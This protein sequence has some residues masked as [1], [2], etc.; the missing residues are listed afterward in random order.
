[1]DKNKLSQYRS[2][3]KEIPRIKSDI[4]KLEEKL[5]AVP[6]VK[7]KVSKSGDDFPYIEGHLTV[8]AEEPRTA[9]E[10]RKQIR[11]KQILLNKAE[12]DKTEIVKFIS[13]IEN[14]IDRQIFELLY[15]GEKRMSQKKVG[16]T[17]GYTQGRISQIINAYLKD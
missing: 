13:S 5:A 15:M 2:L 3:Q 17:L 8:E 6:V 16:E 9:T 10:I 12:K 11:L 14:S 4:L 7:T 1:M